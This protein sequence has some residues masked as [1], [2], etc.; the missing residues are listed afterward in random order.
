MKNE[1]NEPKLN[2][3]GDAPNPLRDDLLAAARRDSYTKNVGENDEPDNQDHPAV[4]QVNEAPQGLGAEKPPPSA[5]K[6]W[7]AAGFLTILLIA[8]AAILVITILRDNR[9]DRIDVGS[10]A[11]DNR[12]AQYKQVDET[13]KTAFANTNSNPSAQPTP[14]PTGNTNQSPN[15]KPYPLNDWDKVPNPPPPPTGNVGD[16]LSPAISPSVPKPPI[17]SGSNSNSGGNGNNVNSTGNGGSGGVAPRPTPAPRN[18]QILEVAGNTGGREQ[19]NSAV[20]SRNEQSSI[21]YYARNVEGVPTLSKLLPAPPDILARKPRFNEVFPVRLLGALHSLGS[22]GL[23][24]MMTTRAVEGD[25]YFLPKGTFFIGRVAGG[26]GNRLFIALVGY[27]D[28]QTG[29]LVALGGDV[30]GVDGGLGMIGK[31]QRLDN[32]FKKF[33]G[34]AWKTSRELGTAYLLGRRGGGGNW[35]SGLDAKIQS[36]SNTDENQTKE[37]ILVQSGQEGYIVVSDLPPATDQPVPPFSDS[38]DAPVGVKPPSA[39]SSVSDTDLN[40]LAGIGEDRIKEL[41]A[42][43]PEERIRALQKYSPRVQAIL[44]EVLK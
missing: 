3:T 31:R 34:D 32:R 25:R 43:S 35:N 42:L 41:L 7:V 11:V 27:L 24:R 4:R 26:E 33:F 30:S 22:G 39:P 5:R 8:V 19:N 1:K 36:L 20:S 16:N 15:P 10:A 28:P 13:L 38:A 21:Y 14:P 6:F 17:N 2:V 23:A 29:G 18:P 40:A 44:R 9:Q 37:Y 12:A